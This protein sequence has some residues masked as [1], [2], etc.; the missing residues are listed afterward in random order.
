MTSTGF[1]SQIYY[2]FFFKDI[3]LEAPSHRKEISTTT[4]QYD[5]LDNRDEIDEI[6]DLVPVGFL[7]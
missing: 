6:D 4:D 3:E 1:I 5:Y 2:R 7:S